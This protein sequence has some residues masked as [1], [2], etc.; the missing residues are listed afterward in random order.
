MSSPTSLHPQ[1]S[2]LE[3]D[4]ID[5]PCFFK[6]QAISLKFINS[7]CHLPSLNDF[8]EITNKNLHSLEINYPEL[9]S[10]IFKTRHFHEDL[11]EEHPLENEEKSIGSTNAYLSSGTHISIAETGQLLP[12]S[13]VIKK[14]SGCNCK[15]TGCLKMYCECFSS[16]KICT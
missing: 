7:I 2:L 10:I 9:P 8:T 6:N 14:G 12:V 15:K 13:P 11:I 3:L 5:D 1:P 4:T 16:G